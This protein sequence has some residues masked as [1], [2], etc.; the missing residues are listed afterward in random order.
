MTTIMNPASS[1]KP[2][3]IVHPLSSLQPEEVL[4]A[5]NLVAAYNNNKPILWKVIAVKEPNK[6]EVVAYTLRVR[7]SRF[8]EAESAGRPAIAPP[9][10]IYTNFYFRKSPHFH[11]ALVDVTAGRVLL[12]RNLGSKVHGPGTPEEMERTHDIAI[13]SELVQKE[14]ARLKLPEGTEVVCEPWP[15][16]RDGIN[17]DE[18]LFQVSFSRIFGLI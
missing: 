2:T 18:R 3:P 13:K 14:I 11:E 8:L 7:L 12:Q 17:D 9:R 10:V 1:I 6:A 16:G 5:R 15:Y 4:R